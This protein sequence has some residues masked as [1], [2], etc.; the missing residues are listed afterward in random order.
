MKFSGEQPSSVCSAS[1]ADSSTSLCVDSGEASLLLVGEV[2][3]C[4]S[5]LRVW[6]VWA[7]GEKSRLG[8]SLMGVLG[9][10]SP[11]VALHLEFWSSARA[12]HSAKPDECRML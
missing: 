4:D 11:W 8:L 9:L 2:L 12:A 5:F 7:G 1:L 3:G 10:L 6:K